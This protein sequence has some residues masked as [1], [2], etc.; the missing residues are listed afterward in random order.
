MNGERERL[1]ELI[2]ESVFLTKEEEEKALKG[3]IKNE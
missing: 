3:G 2:G 1:I